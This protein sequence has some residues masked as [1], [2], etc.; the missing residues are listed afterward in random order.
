ME[1]RRQKDYNTRIDGYFKDNGVKPCQFEYVIYVKLRR[2]KNI[3]HDIV[4]WWSYLYKKN[5]L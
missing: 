3:D 2:E 5:G 4:C 1:S